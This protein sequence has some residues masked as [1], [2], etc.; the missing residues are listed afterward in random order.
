MNNQTYHNT[1]VWYKYVVVMW[2]PNTLQLT[3]HPWQQGHS[4]RH[5]PH[6]DSRDLSC[7]NCVVSEKSLGCV[8][9]FHT[10][11]G[12]GITIRS[13][14]GASLKVIKNISAFHLFIWPPAVW[15]ACTLCR[16]SVSPTEY[17]EDV[18]I[19]SEQLCGHYSF[20]FISQWLL[21]VLYRP[22]VYAGF[23]V[24]FCLAY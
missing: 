22:F 24:H 13:N 8:S 3:C 17:A 4:G 23:A 15:H 6:R 19:H 16:C 10:F 18:Y 5:R 11:W 20:L 2:R 7:L 14:E 1:M 12:F 9:C 21:F